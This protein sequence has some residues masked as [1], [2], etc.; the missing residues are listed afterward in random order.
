MS[1]FSVT[2][3]I[4]TLNLYLSVMMYS[5]ERNASERRNFKRSAPFGITFG[6]PP[7]PYGMKFII[8]KYNI[9][10]AFICKHIGINILFPLALFYYLL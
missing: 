6:V 5:V 1:R 4:D 8:R 9:K 3:H 2:F 7:R 10:T